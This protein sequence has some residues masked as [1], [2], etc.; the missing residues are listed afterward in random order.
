MRTRTGSYR[1][2][3]G[4]SFPPRLILWRLLGDGNGRGVWGTI[5]GGDARCGTGGVSRKAVLWWRRATHLGGP[6]TIT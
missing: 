5:D 6:C 1:L 4:A 2:T 3:S